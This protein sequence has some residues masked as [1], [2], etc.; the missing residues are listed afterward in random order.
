MPYMIH[1][2]T[3]TISRMR[4]TSSCCGCAILGQ[5]L[6][7][8]TTCDTLFSKD[9]HDLSHSISAESHRPALLSCDAQT[10]IDEER[11]GIQLCA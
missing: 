9:S 4:D 11:A 2:I 8:H 7:R 3:I 1:F 6:A 5:R 10:W